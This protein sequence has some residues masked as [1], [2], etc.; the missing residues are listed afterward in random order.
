MPVTDA[1]T[2]ASWT[3]DALTIARRFSHDLRSPLGAIGT[4]SELLS[5]LLT[6]SDETLISLAR[7]IESS[8]TQGLDLV[9]RVVTLLR[10]TYGE[11]PADASVSMGICVDMARG[12]CESARRAAGKTVTIAREWPTLTLVDEWCGLVWTALLAN[13][14]KHGGRKIE[15]GWDDVDGTP[16]FWVRDDGGGLSPAQQADPF[17]AFERLHET[18]HAKGLGLCLVRRLLEL[19]Q[20]APSYQRLPDGR[21]EFGFSL[22]APAAA[23]RPS[24]AVE[25]PAVPPHLPH[26]VEP[27]SLELPAAQSDFAT[28]LV[29]ARRLLKAPLALISRVG[30]EMVIECSGLGDSGAV[31][32]ELQQHASECV[33]LCERVVAS[34]SVIAESRL[35]VSEISIVSLLGAPV[36]GIDGRTVGCIC[37]AD[38]HPR[39]WTDEEREILDEFGL[40]AQKDI[41]LWEKRQRL[42]AAVQRLR[43]DENMNVSLLENSSDCIKLISP[44]GRLLD[45]NT[46]GRMLVEVDELSTI[47][48]VPWHSLWPE[49]SRHLIE[50]AILEA[51]E[52]R[53]GRF[54]GFCPTAK[55][56]PKWW[57]VSVSGVR[58][59]NG[60]IQKLISVSRDITAEMVASLQLAESEKKFRLL[61]DNMSQ[62]AWIAEATGDIG[63]YNQRWFDYTGTTLEEMRGG[64][65]QQFHHPDHLERVVEKFRRCLEAGTVWEDT[66]PLRSAQGEYRWFLSRAVP[67]RDADGRLLQWFGTNTDVT[68]QLETEDALRKASQAKDDF[69]AVLSHEL[70]TPLNPVLLLAS[71]AEARDDL[72]DDVRADYE[73]IRK[74]IE[75]EARLID[76]LLD[77]TR[78][79]RGK[80]PLMLTTLA[81]E[82]LLVDALSFLQNEAAAKD[83]NVV[84]D[85]RDTHQQFQG[86]EVRLR[87]ILWN[88]LRNAVKFTPSGGQITF[89]SKVVRKRLRL[90]IAD[91][92]IGMTAEDLERVFEPFRQ[93]HHATDHGGSRFGGLGLG[94][95]IAKL[96][97]EQ[98]GGGISAKSDGL[99]QGTTITID[100]PLSEIVP[101]AVRRDSKGAL[102]KANATLSGPLR[103]L[104]IEDHDATRHTLAL[105][106]RHRGHAVTQA[107][108]IAEGSAFAEQEKFDLLISDIG[109]PDGRGDE[110]LTGLR[111]RGFDSPAI[112][113]S[114]YGMEPDV[115][116]S[117]QAGFGMHLTKPVSIDELERAL[118]RMCGWRQD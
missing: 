102:A 25:S 1:G 68:H 62:F 17:P 16:H 103:I 69:I 106:L 74:N 104:L 96:L 22:R 92:G 64:G 41:R 45:M 58:D 37:V 38:Y 35:P 20:G 71:A 19:M 57:D 26:F 86:D 111:A 42:T 109:L 78:I 21:T 75:V 81:V 6:G 89:T 55:G 36:H 105:I 90:V 23:A 7:G 118:V 34:G 95:A 63:W 108:S 47:V 72:P 93:G 85:L 31:G 28:T 56:T 80:L 87:Q 94:L 65:W 27:F 112:A 15:L 3:G 10:A 52:G 84:T 100:L 33:E 67:V 76:D 50:Q 8:A 40:L 115:Q 110:L 60:A 83:I 114:G 66:F 54:R 2:G 5:E 49:E 18:R 99:H 88:V 79:L 12:S 70:R 91:N 51:R 73:V 117:R 13:A 77:M 44:D 32:A 113:L 4:S 30:E 61:A 9:S 11:R 48:G 107:A 97:V 29:L 101:A 53:T 46:P 98:H 24:P 43:E 82:N 39:E 14:V 116:R 59:A